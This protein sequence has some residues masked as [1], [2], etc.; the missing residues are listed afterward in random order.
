M[1]MNIMVV[2][3]GGREH[4]IAWKLAQNPKVDTVYCAPGNGGTAME[5]KCQNVALVETDELVKFALSNQVKLTFVGPELNL[6][7]GIVDEF[8][9][10]GLRIFGP[11]RQAAQLEGSKA[12]SKEFMKKY[13]VRTAA[14]ETFHNYSDALG[15]LKTCEY[16]IVI[17]ADGL[18]AGKGVVICED[19]AVARQTIRD[20][21]EQ[22]L[23]G[24]SGSTV[25]IEEFLSGVEASILTITDGKTI[26]PFL[27]AKDHK[28]IQDGGVGPNTGG[29]GVIAPNPYCTA[30][31]LDQFKAEVMEPTLRGIR[32]EQLDYTG[33]IFFGLMITEKGVYNLE[34]NVRMGDPETQAVLSLMES[35]FLTLIEKALAAELEHTEINWKKE[36]ACTVIA[37]SAGYPFHYETGFEISG[38][39][40][41][42][43]L[44]GINGSANSKVFIAGA[45]LSEGLL[46]TS[47]GRVL[48]VTATAGTLPQARKAAYQSMEKLNFEGMYHRND[49]G[50]TETD[51][52]IV[53]GRKV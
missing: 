24:M 20:F 49:I 45:R 39:Q 19:F 29:M 30:E 21:M 53:Q 35:D 12:Y 44:A 42:E 13:G 4:A 26:L 15:Y 48:A 31:V 32:A 34:Y 7:Q 1:T 10:A 22:E 17:K 27:S 36:H 2:G 25:V 3:N 47:G 50:A 33:I 14:Y 43:A 51:A 18:A 38:I 11:S 9:L 41:A 40:E 6:T 46:T 28:Q 16:P 37:A 23:L 5:A 8:K 52:A